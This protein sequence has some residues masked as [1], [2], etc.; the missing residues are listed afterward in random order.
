LLDEPVEGI[1]RATRIEQKHT[2]LDDPEI[3]ELVA[4]YLE[5]DTI[6]ELAT[7]FDVNQTTVQAH[8]ER[9]QVERRPYRKVKP[10]QVAEAAELYRSG[11]SVRGVAKRLGVSPDTTRRLLVE[12]GVVIRCS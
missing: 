10:A 9:Q 3:T 12:A 7:K 4:S 6:D 5:G 8:L 1:R 11:M 2:L